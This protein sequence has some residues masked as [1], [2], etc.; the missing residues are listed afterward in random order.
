MD[1][2]LQIILILKALLEVAGVAF[3]GQG[4]L[5]LLA[6]ASREKN[7]V[8][9]LFRIV[10]SP[11]TRL[12]RAITPRIVLDQHIWLVAFL[13]LLVAWLILTVFKARTCLQ[14]GYP[15]LA[16]SGC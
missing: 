1:T 10:T 5:W 16:V 13:L 2:G 12:T 6:G 7:P 11:V 9:Q 4:L 8:Y 15:H 3:L 14:L